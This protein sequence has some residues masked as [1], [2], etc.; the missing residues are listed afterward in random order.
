MNSRCIEIRKQIILVMK[1][2]EF[3]T[4][5]LRTVDNM[6][7]IKVF[8]KGINDNTTYK[9]RSIFVWFL[10]KNKTQLFISNLFVQLD[11]IKKTNKKAS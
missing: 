7:K 6:Q 8:G 11:K 4:K 2:D 10:S 5:T 3:L 9:N 1:A